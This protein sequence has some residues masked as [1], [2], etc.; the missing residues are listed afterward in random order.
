MADLP[1]PTLPRRPEDGHKGSFGEVVVIGGSAT[2]VG[3]PCFSATA[4]LRAGCGLVRLAVPAEILTACLS[5]EPS[6]IGL[7]L[8]SDGRQ[9][10]DQ[11]DP[12][13]VLAIGPGL[14]SDGTWDDLFDLVWADEHRL[15][16]DAGALTLLARR[17]QNLKARRAPTVLTPHAGECA[18]LLKALA[19]AGDPTQPQQRATL[20]AAL[21]SPTAAVVVLKGQHTVISD[22]Q[23]TTINQSGNA[24][25]AIPGSGD[26]LTGAIAS[27]IAQGLNAFDAARVGVHLH[28]LAGDRWRDR[29]GAVGLLARELADLLPEARQIFSSV[30]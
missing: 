24:V 6:A 22:G 23:R 9:L 13:A 18:R 8:P 7:I 15:V 20:A 14:A 21:A 3:A 5:I 30:K 27:L 12:R 1:F 26:V 29:H 25:L 28:G 10:L 4:A 11:L 19:I 17:G 2:M 16:V